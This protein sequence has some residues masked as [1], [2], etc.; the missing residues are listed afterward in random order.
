[1]TNFENYARSPELLAML[2]EKAVDDAL[3]AEG[4]SLNLKYPEGLS[5]AKDDRLVTWESWLKE[6]M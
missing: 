3:E 1:M 2:I 4:C 6:E 5:S